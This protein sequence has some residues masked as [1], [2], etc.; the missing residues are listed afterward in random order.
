M[1]DELALK[2]VGSIPIAAYSHSFYSAADGAAP[3]FF[4][5]T[6]PPFGRRAYCFEVTE[7]E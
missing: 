7:N 4:F 6:V 3:L 5:V 1:L 2:F